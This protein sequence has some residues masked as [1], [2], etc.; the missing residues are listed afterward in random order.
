MNY[1]LPEVLEDLA[2]KEVLVCAKCKKP[3]IQIF[4]TLVKDEDC[5]VIKSES[6]VME[7]TNVVGVS[8]SEGEPS[9]NVVFSL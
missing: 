8:I 4:G 9:V 1:T 5:F 7:I 2:E 3:K 6:T